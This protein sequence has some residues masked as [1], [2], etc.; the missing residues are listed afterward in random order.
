MRVCL[1]FL[2]PCLAAIPPSRAGI[3]DAIGGLFSSFITPPPGE[4]NSEVLDDDYNYHDSGPPSV[5]YD[6]DYDYQDSRQPRVIG[7]FHLVLQM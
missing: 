1:L 4:Q 2:F 5:N 6:D 7:N 3:F